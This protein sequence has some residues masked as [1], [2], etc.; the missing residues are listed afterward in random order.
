VDRLISAAHD[1]KEKTGIKPKYMRMDEKLWKAKEAYQLYVGE[2]AYGM[3]V[4]KWED[5][6]AALS[7]GW[8]MMENERETISKLLQ[9]M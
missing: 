3:Y 9:D 6:V 4:V 5:R 2:K 7:A 1:E 8:H